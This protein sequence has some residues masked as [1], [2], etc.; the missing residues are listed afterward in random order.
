MMHGKR[1]TCIEGARQA[2]AHFKVQVPVLECAKV[3]TG[4]PPKNK[5]DW[6]PE[7][8]MEDALKGALEIEKI[9]SKD[10]FFP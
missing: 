9:C 8:Y 1:S 6:K 2:F 10:E 3:V 5:P 7:K 4:A